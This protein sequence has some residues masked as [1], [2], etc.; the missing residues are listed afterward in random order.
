MASGALSSQKSYFQ[1]PQPIVVGPP[2]TGYPNAGTYI[3]CAANATFVSNWMASLGLP[4]LNYNAIIIGIDGEVWATR[5]P[6]PITGLPNDLFKTYFSKLSNGNPN[7][8]SA[9]NM[10]GVAP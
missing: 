5:S 3:N 7:A 6:V 8:L 2:V 4:N 1:F 9:G 10:P